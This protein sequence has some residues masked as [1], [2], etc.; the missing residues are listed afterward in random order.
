MQESTQILYQDDNHI[1]LFFTDL[2]SGE[3]IPSNQLVIVDD[4]E[5]AIFDPGGELTYTPLSIA[6][7]KHVD[8][9]KS[10]KYVF[11]SH[12]DPDIITS[13]PRWL[14][15]SDC[16][17]V[18]SKLWGRFL[19]HLV[20]SFVSGSMN[21]SLYDRLVEIP[22]KGAKVPL[23]KN[24]ILAIPAHF[25]HSVG[26]FHFYDPV[27]KILF[28]GDVGAAI[29]PGEDHIPVTDMKQHIPKMEGFHRRY[30]A[31]NRAARN[32]VDRVRK[33]D[34]E[35]MVPQ[36]GRPFKGKETIEEFYRW[37]EHLKCGVDLL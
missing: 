37:F 34:I 24:Q 12:Q 33:L 15:H 16:R 4:G 30:M 17:V 13:L 27:S 22:D 28:S 9:K 31:S 23:G 3:A 1:C 29:T 32:W 35:I 10:L 36:H 21:K 19:P 11:A 7:A 18:T 14:M 5:A 26:N 25:L 20:S 2:V 6:L 8:V